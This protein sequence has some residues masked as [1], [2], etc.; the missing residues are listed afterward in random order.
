M[1]FNQM[2]IELFRYSTAC[3]FC[4]ILLKIFVDKILEEISH[5]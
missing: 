4:G 5:W 3:F 2:I 1:S